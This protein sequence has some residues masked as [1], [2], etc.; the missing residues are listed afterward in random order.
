MKTLIITGT[1]TA[2]G[3][4]DKILYRVTLY[5]QSEAHPLVIYLTTFERWL[6]GYDELQRVCRQEY[7]TRFETDL[8]NIISLENLSPRPAGECATDRLLKRLKT[9]KQTIK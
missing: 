7:C 5:G 4:N 1:Y 2:A 8:F 9:N 6:N 3:P